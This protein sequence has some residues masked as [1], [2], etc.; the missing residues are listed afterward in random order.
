MCCVFPHS[1][2]IPFLPG[3]DAAPERARHVGHH[4]KANWRAT[5][6]VT[7]SK[8]W[9]LE[10]FRTSVFSYSNKAASKGPRTD[11]TPWI[12]LG[13]QR[14][15]PPPLA[16]SSE[17]FYLRAWAP[18]SALHCE[19]Q[20]VPLGEKFWWSQEVNKHMYVWMDRWMDGQHPVHV[21]ICKRELLRGSKKISHLSFR[22]LFCSHNNSHGD[23]CW[24]GNLLL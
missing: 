15:F 23:G 10:T 8:T 9:V 22:I 14:P 19:P 1:I 4:S 3:Q 13:T 11:I 20:H 16:L 6:R 24:K 18:F 21:W 12:S 7:R 5:K 2:K 17:S